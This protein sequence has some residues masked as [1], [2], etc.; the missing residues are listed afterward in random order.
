SRGRIPN[1][2]P[3]PRGKPIPEHLA[4]EW[5]GEGH[6]PIQS[7][8]EHTPWRCHDCGHRWSISP[9]QRVYQD[10]GCPACRESAHAARRAEKAAEVERQ[11]AA[12]RARTAARRAE[13]VRQRAAEKARHTAEVEQR[14][15]ERVRPRSV[16]ALRPELAAQMVGTD[17]FD[18]SLGS[19]LTLTWRC[20]KGHE[21]ETSAQSRVGKGSG[22]PVCYGRDALPGY[23]DLATLHPEIA[24]QWHPDNDRTPD[25]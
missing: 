8:K 11:R 13:R 24:A 20:D 15:L 4:A 21:W 7:S 5:T 18:V 12:S 2:Q 10:S 6:L 22:C 23:N 19:G 16:G 14:R 1:C 3:P 17:P 25:M 9:F